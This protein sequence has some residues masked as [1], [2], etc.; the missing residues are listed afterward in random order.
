MVSLETAKAIIEKATGF[1]RPSAAEARRLLRQVTPTVGRFEDDGKTPNNPALPL[2]HYKSVVRLDPRFDPAAIFEVLF[3]ANGWVK[4]W[5]D[6]IYPYNHFHTATHEVIGIARGQCRVRYGGSDGTIYPLLA[7]DVVVV[8]A[9]VGH[10]RL[11]ASRSLL[12]VGAYPRNGGD[13]DEPRP[14][15]IAH[16]RAVASIATVLKPT[17]DPVGGESGA[18][19]RLWGR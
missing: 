11:T 2:L 15:E 1:G 17:A 19:G 13:Y 6:G 5:R 8:P 12:V 18:L 10:R 9:G 16:D 14:G 3:E 7:G 4:S